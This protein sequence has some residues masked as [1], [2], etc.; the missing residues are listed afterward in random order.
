MTSPSDGHKN[1]DPSAPEAP[2]RKRYD[3]FE[4]DPKVMALKREKRRREH[5]LDNG[6]RRRRRLSRIG[7]LTLIL[8]I[9]L[10]A[11]L[12]SFLAPRASILYEV[13]APL[14]GN[15]T[16]DDPRYEDRLLTI[17]AKAIEISLPGGKVLSYRVREIRPSET[18]EAVFYSIK[19][20]DHEG[21]DHQQV[22]LLALPE[23]QLLQFRNRP[24]VIWRQMT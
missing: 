18:E 19:S 24:G 20:V 8:A 6:R 17:R 23:K 11:A 5:A 22:I 13:P 7:I 21:Q 14:I 3:T 16:T 1:Q 12:F 15:W 10:L 4:P 2:Y 9:T